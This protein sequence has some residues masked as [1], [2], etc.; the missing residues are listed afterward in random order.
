MHVHVVVADAGAA[1]D[2]ADALLDCGFAFF[3]GGLS[4]MTITS[5][6][7]LLRAMA[8]LAEEEEDD[9]EDEDDDEDDDGTRRPAP[10]GLT[11]S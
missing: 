10:S 3:V 9:E 4:S 5:L 11:R 6:S 1:D 7:S 2:D 8:R